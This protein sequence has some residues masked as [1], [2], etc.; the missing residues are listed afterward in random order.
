MSL[1]PPMPDL[2]ARHRAERQ[3]FLRYED[4]C[5]DGR[6]VLQAMPHTIGQVVWRGALGDHPVTRQGRSR[7]VIPVLTRLVIEV[8]EA[9]V[10]LFCPLTGRG[11]FQLAHVR[12]DD[13]E[14]ERL[15]MNM[16]VAVRGREGLH[17]RPPAADAAE[18]DV[19]RVF[20]EHVFTRLHAPAGQ[21]K[22]T[23]F[24]AE[25]LEQVPQARH[26]WRPPADLL[27][28]PPSAR[29]LDDDFASDAAPVVF[30]LHHTDANQHVNSLVY[31]RLFEDAALRRFA[32]RGRDTSAPLA[33][34]VEVAYRKPCFAGQSLRLRLRAFADGDHLGATG[35][36]VPEG[37]PLERGHCFVRMRFAA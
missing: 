11:G 36:F 26:P 37:Q 22:V 23:R 15:I 31:P 5:Q 6:V 30:G 12:G 4:E 1:V 3:V 32:A 20:A 19:G 28:L 34:A 16:W 33:R 7:G 2:P 18:V 8:T 9:T 14:V 21:R 10:S 25:G 13:G 24:E 29:P 17:F 27:E 35:A